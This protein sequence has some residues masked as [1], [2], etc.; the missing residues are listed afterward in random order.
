MTVFLIGVLALL[1]VACAQ[2]TPSDANVQV[3]VSNENV[4][5]AVQTS[6]TDVS[7]DLK[8]VFSSGNEFTCTVNING[9][10]EKIYAKKDYMRADVISEGKEAH[11]LVAGTDVY[12]WTAESCYK[13]SASA[14][15]GSSAQSAPQSREQIETQAVN[16]R[17]TP[18]VPSDVFT[19]PSNCQDLN[20]MLQQAQQMGQQIAQ[21]NQP[22]PESNVQDS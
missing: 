21:E 18:G 15:Q 4:N 12:I 2:E 14:P 7:T 10:N 6:S 20:A 22:S 19:P 13:M 8:S 11:S 5:V 1:M 3:V 16:V 17:C 9:T